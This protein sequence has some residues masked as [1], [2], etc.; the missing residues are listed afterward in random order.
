MKE[1]VTQVLLAA[2]VVFLVVHLPFGTALSPVQ[3]GA[4]QAQDVLRGRSLEIVNTLERVRASI[5]LHPASALSCAD[6][7]E[8]PQRKCTDDLHAGEDHSETGIAFP[9][10]LEHGGKLHGKVVDAVTGKPAAGAVVWIQPTK[11]SS[12]GKGDPRSL[13][14][15]QTNAAGEYEF[16]HLAAVEYNVWALAADR[17]CAALNSVPVAADARREAP[18]LELIEGTWLEGRVVTGLTGNAQPLSRD[19]KTG[20]RLRIGLSGPSRPRSGTSLESCAVD[21]EG[22]FRLRVPPGRNFPQILAPGVWQQTWRMEKFARGIDVEDDRTVSINFRVLDKGP[23]P[24]PP[25][26]PKRDPVRLPVPVAA[27]RD[28]AETLRD[29]GGWYDLDADGHVVKINMV[30]REDSGTRYDNRY[31]N[32]DEAL[33]IAPAFPRLKQLYL[34]EGQ[35][36]DESLACLV[37]LKGLQLFWIW[38]ATAITDEGA[39]HLANLENLENIQIH[40]SRIGDAALKALAKLPKLSRM[41]LQ[42]DAFTDAGLAHLADMQQLRGLWIGVSQGKITDAGLAHLAGLKGLVELDVQHSQVTDAGLEHLRNLKGLR[43]L[44]L[45]NTRVTDAGLESLHEALPDLKV[46]N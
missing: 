37:D 1:R 35:A 12:V 20:E 30:H 24:V 22:R 38:N 4:G 31:T 27:E 33:R 26:R 11:Q 18:D 13:R 3:G 25:A 44:Y 15:A 29:L 8:S 19:P 7:N 6:E 17:T 40:G 36:T 46:S 9:T 10:Q 34:C 23:G 5:K 41:Y 39:R 32:S 16:L 45:N 21:D 43:H 42:E 2:V 28:L 14:K